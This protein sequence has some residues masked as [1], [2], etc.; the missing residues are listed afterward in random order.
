[1]KILKTVGYGRE[2]KKIEEESSSCRCRKVRKLHLSLYIYKISFS[3]WNRKSGN[4]FGSTTTSVGL[5]VS[6]SL[7]A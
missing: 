3:L 7:G 4:S 2:L 1:M 5:V 6:A